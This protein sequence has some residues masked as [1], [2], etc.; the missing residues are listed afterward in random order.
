MRESWVQSLS[1]EDHW[2]REMATYS[3][4]LPGKMHGEKSL[5][6]YSPW[7]GKIVGHD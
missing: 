4:T 5:A 3:S 2:E 7:S 6:G 1:G